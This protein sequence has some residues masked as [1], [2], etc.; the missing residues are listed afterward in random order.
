MLRKTKDKFI[1]LR[2]CTENRSIM[3]NANLNFC[4]LAHSHDN[5]CFASTCILFHF[6]SF[7]NTPHC[8]PFTKVNPQSMVRPLIKE[9]WY[10]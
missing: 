8:V 10:F 9:I 6:H 4:Y 3:R 2:K 5:S 7:Q 1:Y